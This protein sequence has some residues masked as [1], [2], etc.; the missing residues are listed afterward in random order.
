MLNWIGWS[1]SSRRIVN[2]ERASMKTAEIWCKERVWP[3]TKTHDFVEEIQADAIEAAAQLL[4]PGPYIGHKG[5]VGIDDAQTRIRALK[6]S[7]P[8]EHKKC[9]GCGAD[10]MV[11]GDD[12]YS[13]RVQIA[14]PNACFRTAGTHTSEK[15]A[16]AVWNKRDA[17]E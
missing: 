5:I 6:P 14:C 2:I 16:W 4:E 10:G 13:T 12:N 17:K 9:P 3:V 1:K 15:Q 7:P 11:T 8:V